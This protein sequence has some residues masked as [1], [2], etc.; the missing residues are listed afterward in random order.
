M[1][2]PFTVSVVQPAI[3]AL[4]SLKR[5]P[6]CRRDPS[7][8]S[9]VRVDV[10]QLRLPLEP[11]QLVQAGYLRGRIAD[12][13]FGPVNGYREERISPPDSAASARDSMPGPD[14]ESQFPH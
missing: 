12:N 4:G 6:I 10:N 11:L 3:S 13:K 5:V 1:P 2:E 8:I 14:C 9:Q 7:L